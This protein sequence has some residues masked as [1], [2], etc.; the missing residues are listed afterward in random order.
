MD[1]S[2]RNRFTVGDVGNRMLIGA[3]PPD[4]QELETLS[5]GLLRSLDVKEMPGRRWLPRD[6]PSQDQL[7][8]VAGKHHTT[9]VTGS[10]RKLRVGNQP[11]AG[12]K[13]IFRPE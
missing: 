3:Q 10:W 2:H 9:L 1:R 8:P 11:L 4:L 12:Y 6:D 7:Q 13:V 5:L